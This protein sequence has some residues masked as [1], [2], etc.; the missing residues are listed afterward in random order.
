MTKPFQSSRASF[1]A[2]WDLLQASTSTN[3]RI[4]STSL[5]VHHV[6][7][8]Q[9]RTRE[10]STLSLPAKLDVEA[11]G[12]AT[13]FNASLTIPLPEIPFDPMTKIQLVVGHKTGTSHLRSRVR[14]QLHFQ[15]LANLIWL[16]YKWTWPAFRSVAFKS[17]GLMY[18]SV[19]DHRTSVI[20]FIHE[21]LPTSSRLS[22]RASDLYEAR[23]YRCGAASENSLHILVCP[24]ESGLQWRQS[25]YSSLRTAHSK[26]P[27]SELWGLLLFC[28]QKFLTKQP[29][30][31]SRVSESLGPI[32][33]SQNTIGWLHL[34]QGR[35]SVEWNAS[36]RG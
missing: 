14:Y 35:W 30:L 13:D 9:D 26:T 7:G 22:K 16:R 32:V 10:I 27:P 23:C 18:R 2:N 1:R 8:H 3:K 21:Q 31:L 33:R 17:G 29:I 12:L 15:A 5:H 28:L 24:S 25:L 11:D 20:K 34:F 36:A 6:K 19:Y 4:S